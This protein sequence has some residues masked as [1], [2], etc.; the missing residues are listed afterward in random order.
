MSTRWIS[1][2]G[3]TRLG[4]GWTEPK[5]RGFAYDDENQLISV[6]ITNNWRNDFVCD[7]KMRRRIERDYNWSGGAWMQ[8]N[9]IHFVYD[10]NLVIQ[11]RDINNQ[12]Q[13]T[14]TRGNDLS[15]TLQGAGDIGGLLA[16]S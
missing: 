6:Y 14:Y 5:G 13:V 12:P 2:D 10:G 8:T 11:E 3:T 7:G 16:R 4:S 1:D 15:G 9:E